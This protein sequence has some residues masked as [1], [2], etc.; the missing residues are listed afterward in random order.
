MPS[1][2]PTLATAS[3]DS[4]APQSPS[5]II[6]KQLQPSTQRLQ[7]CGT[8]PQPSPGPSA[9]QQD[10]LGPPPDFAPYDAEYFTVDDDNVVS[11]D[12][13]LNLDGEA[14]HQF[15]LSQSLVP[16]KYQLHCRGCHTETHYRYTTHHNDDGRSESQRESYTETITDFDFLI[17]IFPGPLTTSPSPQNNACGP[18]H[19][20]VADSEPAYRG[21][22]V[23][24]VE[25]PSD[26]GRRVARR[27]ERKEYDAWRSERSGRGLPPWISSAYSYQAQTSHDVNDWATLKSSKTL[28]QWA[29]EYCMSPK[30]LKEF[31]YEKVLYG[32]DIR[33]LEE[34]VHATILSTR[35]NGCIQVSFDTKGSRVCIRADNRLSRILSNKWCKF[36][37]II[38]LIFPFVWLFKRFHS[39][40]GGRWEV[41]GGAYALKRW[42]PEDQQELLI[43][44][45]LILE[46]LLPKFTACTRTGKTK[47]IGMKEG[48]WFRKW[49]AAIRRCVASR[50]QSSIPILF[51]DEEE[52]RRSLVGYLDGY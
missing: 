48:E 26:A 6:N 43:D 22:M 13:H 10:V 47:L 36:L 8:T 34:A 46:P 23:Q 52:E 14:L 2:T 51:S 44:N 3:I 38:L 28:R 39:R 33:Q 19:W 1:L 27:S 18:T 15:L 24:E 9:L 11:H 42:V 50:Y 7:P 5:M 41:C 29:D 49:E 12:P 4:N 31:V 37:S 25:L 35:Y 40:G 30:Y 21:R 45:E 16:P 20:S 32:W 17:D